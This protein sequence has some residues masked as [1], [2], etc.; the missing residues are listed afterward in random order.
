LFTKRS[1]FFLSPLLW[2][3]FSS[4]RLESGGFSSKSGALFHCTIWWLWRSQG[5]I[6]PVAGALLV[7]FVQQIALRATRKRLT[8]FY[9]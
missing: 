1:S 8:A 5:L 4:A 6:G 2:I 3:I 7:Q 9:L